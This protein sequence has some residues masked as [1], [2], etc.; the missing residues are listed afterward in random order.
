MLMSILTL[1]TDA[2]GGRGGIAK[3]NSDFLTAICSYPYFRTIIAIPR[4]I[5]DHSY[6]IPNKL[7]YVTNS[8]K[9]KLSYSFSALRTVA[10]SSNIDLI[11]CGHINLIPIAYLIHL[12]TKSPIVLIVHGVDAWQPSSSWLVN[13]LATK[14]NGLISVSSITQEKFLEWTNLTG[15]PKF[16]LPNTVDLETFSPGAKNIEL[17]DRYQLNDKTIIMTLGRLAAAEAYKGFDEVLDVMPD[18]IQQIPNLSYLIVGEGDDRARL[19]SKAN[20][21]GLKDRVMFTGFIAEEEK[22]DHYR[23][24]DAYVMPGRGEGFGIVYL[25]AMACGI[26]VVAS[27]VDGSREAVRDGM[28]GILVDPDNLAEIK[29]GILE[30][31]TRPSGIVPEGLDYF[32]DL[33]FEKRVH[34]ILDEIL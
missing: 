33:N 28:L 16:I 2:F 19:E 30:A 1:I 18:L 22:A 7:T 12:W 32:S 17:I 9:D 10:K 29:A 31:L 27:K 4:N 20:S 25:E 34:A 5:I 24:A 8:R 11:I 13:T 21:L 3:F 23:L 6:R 26:P 14:I 15:T